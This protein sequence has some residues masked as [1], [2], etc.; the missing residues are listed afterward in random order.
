MTR[1]F[2]VRIVLAHTVAV[3]ADGPDEAIEQAWTL[4]HSLPYEALSVTLVDK[5]EA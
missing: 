2:T 1:P 5:E 4:A 3:A